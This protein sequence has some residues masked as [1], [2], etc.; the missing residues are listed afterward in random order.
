MIIPLNKIIPNPQQPRRD[1]DAAALEELAASIKAHG[2]IN[3][4]SVEQGHGNYILIDGER[5]VRAARLAGLTEI[6][7]SVRPGLNGS[8][9]LE[10]A[11]LA[12]VANVQRADMNPIERAKAFERL[13]Q[14]GLTKTEIARQVGMHLGS[15]NNAAVLLRLPESVQEYI[16][17]G[18]VTSGPISTRSLM[19]M[20][21]EEMMLAACRTAAQ[22][23]MSERALS[24]LCRR[25][26]Q[27]RSQ[28]KANKRKVV[29]AHA[30][31][32]AWTGNHWNM[33]AQAGS[34]E[35]SADL[36]K[37]A[38]ETCHECVLYEEASRANCRECPGP[39][40]LRRIAR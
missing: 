19:A 40:L 6:E 23:G 1:F 33:I 34:P 31:V 36:R 15:I 26:G 17:D 9:A 13:E 11:I 3:P 21:D 29:E 16:A 7:A 28:S 35:L 22:F 2:V 10:R 5:R 18:R 24:N 12:V 20:G 39:A 14:A 38:E 25:M 8:G 30:V 37:A 32:T 27:G 4:I